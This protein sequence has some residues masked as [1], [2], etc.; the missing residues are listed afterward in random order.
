MEPLKR[1][2][3]G[4]APAAEPARLE[5]AGAAAERPAGG[6]APAAGLGARSRG[7]RF[8]LSALILRY[9]AY[10]LVGVV[11]LVAA[12]W[13]AFGL[14]VESG[15]VTAANYGDAALEQTKAALEEAGR[16]EDDAVPS[17]YWWARFSP[18]GAL[19]EGDMPQK[20]VDS[21]RAAAFEGLSI[22][23]STLMTSRYEAVPLSDG[24]VAVL[25]YE[26]MPQFASKELRDALPNPQD[27]LFA[28]FSVGA[29]VLLVAVAA[30]ASRVLQRKMGPLARAAARIEERDLGFEVERSAVREIDAVLAAVE[31]MRASLEASLEAQWRAEQRDR[32]QI[33]AL[34]HD[35]KTPL[36]VVRGN[37]DLLLECGLDGEARSCAE[38][39][40]TGAG[41][42]ERVVAALA[43]AACGAEGRDARRACGPF[44]A[45]PFVR[46]VRCQSEALA[47]SAGVRLRCSEGALPDG[48]AGD[49]GLLE[50]AEMNLVANAVEHAPAGSTVELSFVVERAGGEAAAP[51]DGEDALGEGLPGETSRPCGGARTVLAVAVRDEGPGF[52]PE[53]LAHGCERFWRGDAA[54]SADGHSGLG[55]FIAASAARTSGG[56]L[57]LSNGKG[58]TGACATLRIPVEGAF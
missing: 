42:L 12:V 52:S 9:F 33:A 23:Y 17:C 27:L 40:A 24:T 34:A 46:R 55:L 16:V 5:F 28:A 29:V 1:R 19:I 39:A 13:V 43:D 31:R 44:A 21:S 20:R 56:S 49:E 14:L 2:D 45:R 32:E 15:A 3:G 25:A 51:A 54:R 7:F 4:F 35:L 10:V 57:E 26:Y 47:T 37:V 53:A 22:E 30:R 11:M 48:L 8:P 6:R 41:Q 38:D 50:R 58:R 36:T 18:D